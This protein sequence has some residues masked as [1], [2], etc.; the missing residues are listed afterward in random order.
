MKQSVFFGVK[1]DLDSSADELDDDYIPEA[2]PEEKNGKKKSS[3]GK[4]SEKY[5]EKRRERIAN[6]WNEMLKENNT[7]E[8]KPDVSK[9]EE[10]EECNKNEASTKALKIAQALMDQNK[11]D[12]HKIVI[13][14]GKSYKVDSQGTFLNTGEEKEEEIKG[15][16]QIQEENQESEAKIL[17]REKEMRRERARYLAKILE[18]INS[19]TRVINS[20]AKSKMD[21]KQFSTKQQLDKKFEQNRKNGYLEK[22]N[23]INIS[24]EKA[25]EIASKRKKLKTGESHV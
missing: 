14:A 13:F 23:F 3:S 20:M 8:I 6:I 11:G 21:W 4:N 19:K 5:I 10:I 24:K 2:D 18:K 1:I 16:K 12:A 9:S 15:E 22:R 7:N 25:A 17:E